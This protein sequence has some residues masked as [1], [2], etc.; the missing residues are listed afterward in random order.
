MIYGEDQDTCTMTTQEVEKK[1]SSSEEKN[2]S[3][4]KEIKKHFTKEAWLNH[5]DI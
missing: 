4:P 5:A 1:N 2:V 3:L